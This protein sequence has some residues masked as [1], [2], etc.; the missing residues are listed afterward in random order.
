MDREVLMQIIDGRVRIGI[1]EW[2]ER[3]QLPLHKENVSKL[4]AVKEAMGQLKG[5]WR[6]LTVIGGI[7]IVVINHFWK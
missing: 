2:W 3:Y 1:E 5:S 7:A 6:T 4:N